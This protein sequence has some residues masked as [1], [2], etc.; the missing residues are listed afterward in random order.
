[1]KVIFKLEHN[2]A[3]L[4]L[5]DRVVEPH[6]LFFVTSVGVLMLFQNLKQILALFPDEYDFYDLAV[7]LFVKLL[8]QGFTELFLF[9][10]P[11]IP[12]KELELAIHLPGLLFNFLTRL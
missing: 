2:I 12:C 4:N 7:W 9:K 6:E 1:M 10:R 8:L 3:C 11:G 5:D